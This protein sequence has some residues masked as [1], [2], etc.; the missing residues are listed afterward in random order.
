MLSKQC[1]ITKKCKI[2][3]KH[4]SF[5]KIFYNYYRDMLKKS[6]IISELEKWRGAQVEEVN[7]VSVKYFVK[8]LQKY[9]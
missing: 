2:L 5:L 1:K 3:A 4:E 7:T 6:N 9:C 8:I